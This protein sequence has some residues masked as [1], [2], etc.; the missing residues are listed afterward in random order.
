MGRTTQNKDGFIITDVL[1]TEADDKV[2]TLH[3]WKVV[4][5]GGISAGVTFRIDTSPENIWHAIR[6]IDSENSYYLKMPD[7]VSDVVRLDD[8]HPGS[9]LELG[10]RWSEIRLVPRFGKIKVLSSVVDIK[11]ENQNIGIKDYDVIDSGETPL[12]EGNEYSLSV[13]VRQSGTSDENATSRYSYTIKQAI[14]DGQ[15]IR[16]QCELSM[17]FAYLPGNCFRRF[18]VRFGV[19]TIIAKKALGIMYLSAKSIA[20]VSKTRSEKDK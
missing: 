18:F 2:T 11:E 20:E 1:T 5:K 7:K 6:D 9:L 3:S 10:T 17:S 12:S 8:F 16:S 15:K 13:A 19:G 14:V 4:E